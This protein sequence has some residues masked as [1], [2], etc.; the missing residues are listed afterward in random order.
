M[1]GVSNEYEPSTRRILVV[2]DNRTVSDLIV[3]ILKSLGFEIA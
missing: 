2:E 1:T 3:E